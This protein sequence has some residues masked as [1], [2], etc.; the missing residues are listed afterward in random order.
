MQVVL[1]TSRFLS[2]CGAVNR[3]AGFQLPALY[4][5]KT[6]VRGVTGVKAAVAA[7]A[8]RETLQERRGD[9]HVKGSRSP[10]ECLSRQY[11][12]V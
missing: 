7:V 11:H 8:N 6:P 12:T 1:K 5:K 3:S 4:K 10:P 9:L 2:G